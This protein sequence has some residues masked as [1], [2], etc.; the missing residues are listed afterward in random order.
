MYLLHIDLSI[1][2]GLSNREYRILYILIVLNNAEQLLKS[3]SS[4]F[5]LA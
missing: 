2:E 1:N 3:S 4:V 5:Y